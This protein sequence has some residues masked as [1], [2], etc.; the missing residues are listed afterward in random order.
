MAVPNISSR[1][2]SLRK[3][4]QSSAAIQNA[5]SQTMERSAPDASFSIASSCC[6]S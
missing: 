3:I 1:R 6:A 4:L 5:A 2:T